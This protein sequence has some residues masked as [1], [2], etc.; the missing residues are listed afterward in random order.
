[1]QLINARTFSSG[2]VGL[3]YEV[4]RQGETEPAPG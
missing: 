2:M 4:R 1:M 3:T